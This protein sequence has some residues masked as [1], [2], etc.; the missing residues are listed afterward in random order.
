MK[1]D[2]PSYEAMTGFPPPDSKHLRPRGRATIEEWDKEDRLIYDLFAS[3]SPSFAGNDPLVH[4]VYLEVSA[5]GMT[6]KVVES[7]KGEW[8]L[9][10][11]IPAKAEQT[12]SGQP[13]TQSRQ[14]KE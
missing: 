12:G 5:D 7:E 13:A 2:F 6:P 9:G 1:V 3:P 4:R 8:R 11:W 14:P 10:D